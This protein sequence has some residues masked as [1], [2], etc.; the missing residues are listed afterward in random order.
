MESQLASQ[1]EEIERLRRRL[2]DKN[3]LYTEFDEDM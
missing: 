3:T 1:R 2:K